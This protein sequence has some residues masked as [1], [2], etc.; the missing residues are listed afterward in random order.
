MRNP[1]NKHTFLPFFILL[2]P[3][4][5]LGPK[6]LLLRN[7]EET[8]IQT[9]IAGPLELSKRPFLTAARF[10]IR[11]RKLPNLTE[12]FSQMS[13]GQYRTIERESGYLEK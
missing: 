2:P 11:S 9:E 7:R 5:R 12:P 6:L 1:F 4:L 3:F 8:A 10:F 13:F